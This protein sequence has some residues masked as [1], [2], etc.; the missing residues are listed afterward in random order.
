VLRVDENVATTWDWASGTSG[1]VFEI[2]PLDEDGLF[3][4][5]GKDGN[6]FYTFLDGQGTECSFVGTG[7]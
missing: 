3:L 5:G 7:P 2:L 6:G 1:N 4:A